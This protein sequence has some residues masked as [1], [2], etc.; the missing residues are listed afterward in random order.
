MRTWPK[1]LTLVSLVA[2]LR[3]DSMK[4]LTTKARPLVGKYDDGQ[5]PADADAVV[6]IR[7]FEEGLKRCEAEGLPKQFGESCIGTIWQGVNDR[8]E[9]EE[10]CLRVWSSRLAV[11][12]LTGKISAECHAPLNAVHTCSRLNFDLFSRSDPVL[13]FVVR[14]TAARFSFSLNQRTSRGV[15]MMK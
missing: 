15:P 10:I 8:H 4:R 12:N 3:A 13:F 9:R 1:R 11:S 2:C 6:R 5:E 7:S 14:N